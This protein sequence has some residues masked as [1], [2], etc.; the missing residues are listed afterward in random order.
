MS[1]SSFWAS[2][3]LDGIAVGYESKSSTLFFEVN[4]PS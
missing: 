3:D 4:D 2:L 1:V